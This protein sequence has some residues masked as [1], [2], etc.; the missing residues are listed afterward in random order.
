MRALFDFIRS[1]WLPLS[2]LLLT[3]ITALSLWPVSSLPDVPGNDKLHHYI[4]YTALMLPVALRRPANRLWIAL[5]F[6]AWSGAIELIQ[7]YVNRYGEWLDLG[8]N[9]IGLASGLLLAALIRHWLPDET[10]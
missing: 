3:T 1:H 2:A 8:A 6:L 4:A 9:A 5:L 10:S 7:P